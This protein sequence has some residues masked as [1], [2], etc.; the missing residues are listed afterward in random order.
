MDKAT[1]FYKFIAD[2][3]EFFKGGHDVHTPKGLVE[4]ILSKIELEN[5]TVLVLFN[6]EFVIS[7]VYTY[8]VSPENITF[9]SDHDNK[10][11]MAERFGVKYCTSLDNLMKFDVIVS[12]P[13]YDRGI[14][15]NFDLPFRNIGPHSAFTYLSH[16]NLK[17]D[18]SFAV[19]LPCNFMCLPS[20][21]EFRSWFL[22]NFQIEKINVI[23]NTGGKVFD[24]GLSDIVTIV[25]AKKDSP[26]NT[27]IIWNDSFNVDI[28]KY[29]LWPM[30]KTKE[31]VSIFDKLVASKTSAVPFAGG[32]DDTPTDHILSTHLTRLGQRQNPSPRKMFVKDAVK[33]VTIPVWFGYSSEEQKNFQWEWLGTNHYAYVLSLVQSTPKNQPFLFQYLGEHNFTNTDFIRHF[34]LTDEEIDAISQWKASF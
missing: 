4:E 28:T 22:S 7:L 20:A 3:P 16:N 18:G 1:N 6:I 12:N 33:D 15:T 30:F 13:P 21:S 29:D 19:V 24:I 17:E 26:D 8:G 14:K 32:K 10:T 25:A 23:D 11:L 9:Y 27:S 2:R 34:N 31:S 5:K